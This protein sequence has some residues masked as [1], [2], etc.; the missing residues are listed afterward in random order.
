MSK[1]LRIVVNKNKV[2]IA[3]YNPIKFLDLFNVNYI[4]FTLKETNEHYIMKM[5]D[6]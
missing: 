2:K 5:L 4:H 6:Q 3:V 1:Q